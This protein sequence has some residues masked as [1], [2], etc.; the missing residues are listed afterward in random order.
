MLFH[1][2][3]EDSKDTGNEWQ[4]SISGLFLHKSVVWMIWLDCGSPKFSSFF[5]SLIDI[6]PMIFGFSSCACTK[7]RVCLHSALIA[8]RS[9]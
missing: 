3:Y 7:E 5:Y 6:V 2:K 4:V 9:W 1:V 8:E